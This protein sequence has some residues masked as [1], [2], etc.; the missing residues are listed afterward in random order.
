MTLPAVVD[1][2]RG[3][4]LYSGLVLQRIVYLFVTASE[5][6]HA[7]VQQVMEYWLALQMYAALSVH[8]HGPQVPL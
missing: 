1:Y 5:A 8:E 2:L 6:M 3:E 7:M 4:P